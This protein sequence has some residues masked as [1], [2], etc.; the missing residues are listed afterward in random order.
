MN[1][2]YTDAIFTRDVKFS[3][4]MENDKIRL[5][6]RESEDMIQKRISKIQRLKRKKSSN[7]KSCYTIVKK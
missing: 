7:E 6:K 5:V 1:G 2:S 4:E 3:K